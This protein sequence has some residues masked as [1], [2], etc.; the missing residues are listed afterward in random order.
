MTDFMLLFYCNSQTGM[1]GKMDTNIFN[2]DSQRLHSQIRQIFITPKKPL[3]LGSGGLETD[4]SARILYTDSFDQ[5][6]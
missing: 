2:L 3:S 1:F 6:T 5:I 4:I